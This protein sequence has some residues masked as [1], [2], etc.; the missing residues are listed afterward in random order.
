M[1]LLAG[2]AAILAV[3]G[4]FRFLASPQTGRGLDLFASGFLPYR[5]RLEWPRGVQ[6]EDPVPWSW[7]GP[8]KP[9]GPEFQEIGGDDAPAAS[10]VGRGSMVPG[11]AR[12]R[13]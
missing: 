6:E 8:R 7:T 1:E 4:L 12:R 11:I 13:R 9:D 10:S 2:L 5:A 3:I